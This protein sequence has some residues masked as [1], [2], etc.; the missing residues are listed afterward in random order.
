MSAANQSD[1]HSQQTVIGL[2]IPTLPIGTD[3]LGVHGDG[4]PMLS[5]LTI[6]APPGNGEHMLFEAAM[7]LGKLTHMSSLWNVTDAS[8]VA[9]GAPHVHALQSRVSSNVPNST[10]FVL[11][12][13]G[14]ASEP[15]W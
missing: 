14:H 3:R 12:G 5:E 15:G 11:Y 4:A 2:A 6:T 8:Q 10:T 9:A 1:A 7:P 13:A